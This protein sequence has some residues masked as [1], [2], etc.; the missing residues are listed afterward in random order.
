MAYPSVYFEMTT[1]VSPNKTMLKVNMMA[2]E[3]DEGAA[4]KTPR[5]ADDG[6]MQDG[7]GDDCAQGQRSGSGT[8]LACKFLLGCMTRMM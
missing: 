1:A 4:R 2:D 3:D 5:A 8:M 6:I 7:I